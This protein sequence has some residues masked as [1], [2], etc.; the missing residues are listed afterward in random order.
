VWCEC[1]L[2]LHGDEIR[3]FLE[4]VALAEAFIEIAYKSVAEE[5]P[6]Q[7][8]IDVTGNIERGILGYWEVGEKDGVFPYLCG[9]TTE[10]PRFSI[11]VNL[12]IPVVHLPAIIEALRRTNEEALQS[13]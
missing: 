4:P 10:R 5:T 8:W 6:Q 13:S 2:T 9:E 11:G 12:I 7:Y 1:V 3:V